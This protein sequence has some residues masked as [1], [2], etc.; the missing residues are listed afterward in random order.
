[1]SHMMAAPAS[2]FCGAHIARAAERPNRRYRRRAS[3]AGRA[4]SCSFGGVDRHSARGRAVL[5]LRGRVVGPAGGRVGRGVL[6]RGGAALQDVHVLR[7]PHRQRRRPE[8]TRCRIAT[9]AA[10]SPRPLRKPPRMRRSV[11]LQA[12]PGGHAVGR[13]CGSEG[14]GTSASGRALGSAKPTRLRMRRSPPQTR[15]ATTTRFAASG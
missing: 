6:Q 2:A 12:R 3:A 7:R 11:W 1:M 8:C 10:A 14:V 9:R 4:D 15:S 5:G 13:H